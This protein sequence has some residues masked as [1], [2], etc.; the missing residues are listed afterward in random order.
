[1]KKTKIAILS[2]YLTLFLIGISVRASQSFYSLNGNNHNGNL[3]SPFSDVLH[4]AGYIGC[5]DDTDCDCNEWCDTGAPPPH[6]CVLLSPTGCKYFDSCTDTGTVD[7]NRPGQPCV[8]AQD[9]INIDQTT[10]DD[11]TAGCHII[12]VC[13]L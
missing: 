11:V 4:F 1:M 2:L 10:C 5:T 7:P 9:C 8:F 3:K 12:W 13:P 6:P